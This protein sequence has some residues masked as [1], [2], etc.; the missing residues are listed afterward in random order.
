MREIK[1]L[2]FGQAAL[3]PENGEL[4]LNTAPSLM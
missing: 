2:K 1:R 3:K 4:Q